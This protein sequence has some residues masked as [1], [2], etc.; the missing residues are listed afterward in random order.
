MRHVVFWLLL[1]A[2]LATLGWGYIAYQASF[3]P[4]RTELT[5]SQRIITNSREDDTPIS[6]VIAGRD[7]KYLETA[8]AIIYDA[9]GNAI[10]RRYAADNN[11]YGTN[12]DTILYGNLNGNQLK[13]IAIP[14][15]IWLDDWLTRINSM[16]HYQEGE[17]LASAVSKVIDL[18][19]DY[20]VVI[21]ID[22]FE[23]VVD[24]LGGVDINVPYR[25]CYKDFAADLEI[26]LEAGL[27]EL[28]GAQAATFVRYRK[29]R[30]GGA[31]NIEDTDRLDNLQLMANAILAKARQQNIRAVGALPELIT[32]YQEEI[33]TNAPPTLALEILPR[34]NKLELAIMTLPTYPDTV[35]TQLEGQP[36]ISEVLRVNDKEAEQA[37][38]NF[39]GGSVAAQAASNEVSLADVPVVIYNHSGVQDLGAYVQGQLISAGLAPNR[40]QVAPNSNQSIPNSSSQV[41]AESDWA[42]EAN[43]YAQLLHIGYSQ[44]S[45]LRSSAGKK[46][47]IEIILG[48]DMQ[49]RYGTQVL[50]ARAQRPSSNTNAQPQNPSTPS[51]NDD[52]T[53]TPNNDIV[54]T[55]L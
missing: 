33:E 39:F 5:P 43:H 32:T 45:R 18:P 53:D 36:F 11:A 24:A 28:D 47:F 49:N 29:G 7:R 51:R 54:I 50:L 4:P 31:H 13:L 30:C 20:Y 26:D 16:Y 23:R 12:T 37:I 1:L 52:S 41:R 19:V 21:N 10:G 42:K 55:D 15:D 9:N 3:S 46:A 27:Q 2:G 34:L 35:E 25:M 14:R 48:Q 17:G 8:G 44:V 40:V 6:F 38:A 22:I